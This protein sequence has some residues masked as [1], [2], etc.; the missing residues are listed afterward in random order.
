LFVGEKGI[1][2]LQLFPLSHVFVA[3]QLHHGLFLAHQD[4]AGVQEVML[5]QLRARIEQ[6]GRGKAGL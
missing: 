6:Q 5:E 1:S 2:S 4:A 3:P